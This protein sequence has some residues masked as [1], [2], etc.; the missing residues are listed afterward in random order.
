MR[1]TP[2]LCS[3]LCAFGAAT[4][5]ADLP[6]STPAPSTSSVNIYGLISAGIGHVSNEGGVSRM[7]AI[8]GTNQNPRLG[9]RGSEDLGGG[10]SAVFTLENGFNAMTGALSQNGRAFGR[11]SFVGLADKQFGTL[12]FGRQYD[13]VHDYLGPVL[14]ASNG[15]AIGDND[16]AYNN[17]RIQNSIKYASPRISGLDF[18]AVYG[19]SESTSHSDNEAYSLGVGYR[20]GGWNGGAVYARM[21]N[22]NSATSPNGAVGNDYGSGLLLF[23]KNP[24]NS[25]A[26]RQTI[27]GVGTLYTTGPAQWGIYFSDVKFDYIDNSSLHLRNYNVNLN[28]RVAP[29]VILGAALMR[30]SGSYAPSGAKPKWDQLNLQFNYVLSKRSDLFVNAIHQQAGGDASHANIFGFGASSSRA[31]TML[32]IGMRHRF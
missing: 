4:A 17:I 28:Y 15:V 2:L 12:T 30:T 7:H 18:T 10:L 6:P 27:S 11:Q 29:Q 5:R 23:T 9:F 22:P 32:T 16:N 13:T 26:A 21:N 20:E 14:I 24:A 8:S 3:L 19:L 1:Y 31:Q 25:G